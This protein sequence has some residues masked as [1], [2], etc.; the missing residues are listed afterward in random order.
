MQRSI[1]Y[2][3]NEISAFIL[4]KLKRGFTDKEIITA[5]INEYD[6]VEEEAA[7]DLRLFLNQL[8]E[9]RLFEE[10]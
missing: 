4:N 9:K 8:K 5:L 1:L 3:G 7:S 2:T 6:V 10:V